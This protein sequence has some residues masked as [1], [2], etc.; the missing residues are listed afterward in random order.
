MDAPVPCRAERDRSGRL[1]LPL[2]GRY[3]CSR[4]V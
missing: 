1:A 2:P 4:W 3:R